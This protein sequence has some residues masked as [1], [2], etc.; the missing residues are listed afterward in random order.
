VAAQ[1]Q[2]TME[3]HYGR[4]F[5]GRR[6]KTASLFLRG[7]RFSFLPIMS[8]HGLLDWYIVEGSVNGDQFLYFTRNCLVR[9]CNGGDAAH[10]WSA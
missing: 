2:R 10:T 1:D 7:K 9:R 6:T 5:K 8:A 4:A 3:R